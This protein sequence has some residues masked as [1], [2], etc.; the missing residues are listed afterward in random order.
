V[1]LF[2][3]DEVTKSGSAEMVISVL[4]KPSEY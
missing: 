4:S 2:M 3:P 1:L